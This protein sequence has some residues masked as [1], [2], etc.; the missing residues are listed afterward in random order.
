MNMPVSLLI[1]RDASSESAPLLAGGKIAQTNLAL[2][3]VFPLLA[4][5]T[6]VGRFYARRL[7]R[8]APGLDDWLILAALILHM[9][10]MSMGIL[11]TCGLGTL[12][13]GAGDDPDSF[14]EM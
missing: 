8:M 7:K 1:S 9:A 12:G 4:A 13:G 3:I 11:R 5:L 14:Q 2:S 6:V 10:Q